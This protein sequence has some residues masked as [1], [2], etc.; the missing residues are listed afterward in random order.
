MSSWVFWL[1][2][3][4]LLGIGEMHTGGFFLGPFA[5]G[6]AAGAI[7]GIAGVGTA[8]AFIGF[9]AVSL[10]V[11]AMLRP[12]AMRHRRLPP[13]TRTGAAALVG[14]DAIVLERIANREGVGC[15]KIGGEVWT[16]RS[17]DDGEVIDPGE[18]VQVVEIRGATALVMH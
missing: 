12:L 13:P 14:R 11:L 9:L 5:V 16:A 7:L 8:G 6:A 3:A 17:Y 15:V 10:L 4:C 1:V 18:Q 2:A